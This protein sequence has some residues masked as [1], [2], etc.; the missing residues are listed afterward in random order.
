M[1]QEIFNDK[2]KLDVEI[3]EKMYEV[4]RKIAEF[5]LTPGHTF[6]HADTLIWVLG[7]LIESGFSLE[8]SCDILGIE[9]CD[10]VEDATG[11]AAIAASQTNKG[12]NHDISKRVTIL[13]MEFFR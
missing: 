4:R 2:M 9:K 11:G 7:K 12:E 1:T 6:L 10:I 3:L 5:V 13:F 8:K